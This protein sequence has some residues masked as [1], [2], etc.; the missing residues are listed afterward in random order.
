MPLF[1]VVTKVDKS[2]PEQIA[3][4]TKAIVDK[5]L[6]E[7]DKEPLTINTNSDVHTAAHSFRKGR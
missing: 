4:T 6:A 7:R 1:V 2:S 5:L 3:Q